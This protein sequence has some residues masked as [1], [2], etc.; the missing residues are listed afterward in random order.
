MP[1]EEHFADR[2]FEAVE[3]KGNPLCVGID[4]RLAKVPAAL[5]DAELGRGGDPLAA[6]AEAVGRFAREVVDAVADLVP[7]VKIQ[8]AFFEIFGS[9]G[10]RVLED[11]SFHAQESGLVVIGD[12]KR[13]DIGSTAEAYATAYLGEFDIDE[14]PV[15]AYALDA[16]TVNPYL[17]SDGIEPFLKTCDAFGRGLFVLVKTSNPSSGELQDLD[18]GGAPLYERAATL[19]ETWGADRIGGRGFSSVGAVVGATYPEQGAR[20]RE[21]LPRTPFLIPGFGAQGGKAED[22]KGLFG[23]G[24]LGAVVNSSRGVIFAYDREPYQ[25]RFGEARWQEAVAEAARDAASQL[26][27]VAGLPGPGAGEKGE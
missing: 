8:M 10:I 20:L 23:E 6:G 5:R 15:A 18:A 19:V 21:I 7:A 24:G 13:N 17:G 16:L 27:S 2:L 25:S 14:I 3:A 1:E 11:I 12:G 26:A 22:L 4:P 9:P